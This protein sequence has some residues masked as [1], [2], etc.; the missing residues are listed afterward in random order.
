MR[1]SRFTASS[2]K[3]TQERA[4]W[5]SPRC[6]SSPRMGREARRSWPRASATP[7]WRLWLRRWPRIFFRRCG[8]WRAEA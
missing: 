5:T 8:C 7:T 2:A 4:A 1:S 3:P 6:G